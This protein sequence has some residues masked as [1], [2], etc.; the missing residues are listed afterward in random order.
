MGSPWC[1]HGVKGKWCLGYLWWCIFHCIFVACEVPIGLAPL[2]RDR[3]VHRAKWFNW[4]SNSLLQMWVDGQVKFVLC[5]KQR[6]NLVKHAHEKLGHFGVP[7]TYNLL[8]TQY[9]WRRMQLQVQQFI[10]RCMVCDWD[11]AFFHAPTLHL[12]PLLIMGLGYRWILDFT[13][14]LNLT[15]Q[16]N[17]YVLVMIEH[18]S[19][20]SEL[21]P[22]S[23]CSSEITTYAFLDRVLS[24]F[25]APTKVFTY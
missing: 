23:N 22:L 5:P 1:G 20:W 10:S 14:L 24:R 13:N 17:H 4:E 9:W 15:L 11:Q 8:Q 21:V 18:F 6:E 16:H 7:W 3:V 2:K 19:K 25:G 12:Q